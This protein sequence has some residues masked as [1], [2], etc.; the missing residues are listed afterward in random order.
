MAAVKAVATPTPQNVE[1]FVALAQ[2]RSAGPGYRSLTDEP[3]VAE[4]LARLGGG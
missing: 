1:A 3:D 4:L 2:Q